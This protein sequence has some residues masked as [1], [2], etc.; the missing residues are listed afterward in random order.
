VSKIK[1]AGSWY[2]S[3]RAAADAWAADALPD[4]SVIGDDEDADSAAVELVNFRA[5]E[6]YKLGEDLPLSGATL[7]AALSRRIRRHREAPI[8]TEKNK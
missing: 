4:V 8:E 2:D 5:D 1:Y 7:A 3:E 6:Y